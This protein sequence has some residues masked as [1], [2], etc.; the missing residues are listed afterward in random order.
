MFEPGRA[1]CGQGGFSILEVMIAMVILAIALLGMMGVLLLL[2]QHNTSMDEAS[3]ATK[4][5]QEMMEQLVGLDWA[6]MW[7]QNGLA[8]VAPK[9]SPTANVGLIQITDLSGAGA[10]AGSSTKAEMR[11]AIVTQPGQVTRNPIT[12]VL[13]SRRSKL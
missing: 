4:A 11:V 6:T 12:V 10:G 5:C 2:H 3:L 13:L 7:A 9:L 1:R 8:F